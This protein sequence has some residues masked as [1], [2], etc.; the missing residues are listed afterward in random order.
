MNTTVKCSKKMGKCW[1]VLQNLFPFRPALNLQ[2]PG[3]SF[4]GLI[5]LITVFRALTCTQPV[6]T[7]LKVLE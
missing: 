5:F 1:V 2:G 7:C 4:E 6:N 3:L